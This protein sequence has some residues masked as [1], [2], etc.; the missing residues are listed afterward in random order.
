MLKTPIE[1]ATALMVDCEFSHKEA[2]VELFTMAK[3]DCI[4]GCTPTWLAEVVIEL[5]WFEGYTLS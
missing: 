1:Y 5:N 4:P 2:L 3:E